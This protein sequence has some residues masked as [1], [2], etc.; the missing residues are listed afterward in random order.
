MLQ[1][2]QDGLRSGFRKGRSRRGSGS[3]AVS[4]IRVAVAIIEQQGRYLITQRRSTD[5]LAGL[6][7]FPSSKVETGDTDEAALRRELRERAGVAADVGDLIAHRTH[8]SEGCVVDLVLYRATIPVTRQP[9]PLRVAELRWVA[10][11]ELEHYAFPPADQATTDLLLEIN[12]DSQLAEQTPAKTEPAQGQ[13][14]AMN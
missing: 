6:W 10:P 4:H 3:D 1:D 5:V 8:R 9:R 7:E 13:E 11:H 12:R 14:R 2:R